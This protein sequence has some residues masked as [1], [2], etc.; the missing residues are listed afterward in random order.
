M[1]SL[2]AKDNS[3]LFRDNQ[4]LDT[5]NS[6]IFIGLEQ[7]SSSF[8]LLYTCPDL[9]AYLVSAFPY[10]AH[11]L[12]STTQIQLDLSTHVLHPPSQNCCIMARRHFG[13]CFGQ[14]EFIC[15][16][17]LNGCLLGACPVFMVIPPSVYTQL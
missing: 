6:S 12:L 16:V 17:W 4:G 15:L 5:S 9:V 3:I 13:L 10:D 14:V 8:S 2:S 1:N 11:H 7:P